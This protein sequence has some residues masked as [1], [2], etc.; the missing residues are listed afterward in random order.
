M[1]TNLRSSEVQLKNNIENLDFHSCT[2]LNQACGN[3]TENAGNPF[4]PGTNFVFLMTK[5]IKLA[6]VYGGLQDLI[7]SLKK[8]KDGLHGLGTQIETRLIPTL[9]DG[10]YD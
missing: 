6:L 10:I 1:K 9:C 3:L 7:R 4:H 2:L 5:T 8:T